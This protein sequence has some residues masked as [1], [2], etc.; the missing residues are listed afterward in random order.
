[1]FIFMTLLIRFAIDIT[2]LVYSSVL[3]EN[4][5]LFKNIVKPTALYNSSYM[6]QVVKIGFCALIVIW[7]DIKIVIPSM[8]SVLEFT[9]LFGVQIFFIVV[10]LMFLR[11]S[12]KRTD[13]IARVRK[14]LIQKRT[15]VDL[16]K[17]PVHTE[18]LANSK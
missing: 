7:Y 11:Q 16:M 14:R 10:G 18:L 8:Q 2:I 4:L 3:S 6:F 15:A 1:M 13:V 17:E 9:H 12:I 5:L